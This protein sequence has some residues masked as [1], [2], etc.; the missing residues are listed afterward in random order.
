MAVDATKSLFNTRSI[1]FRTRSMSRRLAEIQMRVDVAA[2]RVLV[3]TTLPK[4]RRHPGAGMGTSY[5]G[6]R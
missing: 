5:P 3:K 6:D 4:Y 2:L 1:A